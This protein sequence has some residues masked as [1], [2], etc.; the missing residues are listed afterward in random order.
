[1]T[2]RKH[3]KTAHQQAIAFEDEVEQEL[4]LG[5]RSS[6]ALAEFAG[7]WVFIGS[8]L[9]AIMC[10]IAINVWLLTDKPFD[11]FPFILLNLVLS[12]VA[13]LQAPIIMMSQNRMETKD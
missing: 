2:K 13:T 7:S 3:P 5:E 6:D 11:P 12:C 1:M 10:W 4:T 9:F 8:F